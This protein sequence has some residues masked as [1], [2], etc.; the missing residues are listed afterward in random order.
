MRDSDSPSATKRHEL[1]GALCTKA[2]FKRF[3]RLTKDAKLRID[4]SAVASEAHFDGKYLLR[5]STA[6][7]PHFSGG[8]HAPH[9]SARS[10]R[11]ISAASSSDV[12]S[13]IRRPR[14]T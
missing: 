11:R 7:V 4:R 9:P 2:G 12:S 13:L 14:S 6:H 10:M 5:S 8:F 1:Y 3:L